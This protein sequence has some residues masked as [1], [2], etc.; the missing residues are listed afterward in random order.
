MESSVETPEMLNGLKVQDSN[1]DCS[2]QFLIVLLVLVFATIIILVA[3]YIVANNVGHVYTLLIDAGSTS[4]KLTVFKWKDWPFI[5]NGYVVEVDT[6]KVSPGISEYND[7]PD[8]AYN[9]L[10]PRIKAQANDWIPARSRPSTRI[11]LAATAGMRLLTLKNPLQ[12]EAIMETLQLSLPRTGL[13]LVN[14]YSDVRIMSGRDEGVYAWITT[15]Y[16]LG[17]FGTRG[18]PP[19]DEVNTVGALDLG[20]ASTQIAFI[21]KDHGAAPHTAP[22]KLFG[23]SYMIYS[24]SY[25]CY[26]KS[27]AENRIWA[28]ILANETTF[29]SSIDNPCLPK[30]YTLS[31]N[32]STI[33]EWPCVSSEYAQELMGSVLTKPAAIPE[34]IT[35]KGTGDPDK[36]REIVDGIFPVKSCTQ[37]PCMFNNVYR[38]ELRGNFIAFAGFSYSA[39]FFGFSNKTITRQEYRDTVDSFCRKSWTEISSAPGFDSFSYIY[40]FDGIYIEALLANYGFQTSESWKSLTFTGKINGASVSWAMGYTIDAS[41][42]IE[43]ASPKIN[44]GFAA[45]VASIVILS[46]I[47]VALVVILILLNKRK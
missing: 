15:N 38:P 21:P 30:D 20:G 34:K 32:T 43:S 28:E 37:S 18:V 3:L 5:K 13:L 6:T 24:Y 47:S 46:V 26:G 39:K 16:L 31:K 17:K 11:F 45:F 4:S 41:G 40:C 27:A 9:A 19:A 7:N 36:C 2:K 29:A 25:L 12:S 8:G 14:P 1:R 33:F 42:M 10:E 44:L 23:K 22:R 35:F